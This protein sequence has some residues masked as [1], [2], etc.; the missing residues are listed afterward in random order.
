MGKGNVG[1]KNG[2]WKGGRTIASNGYVL[3]RVGRDHH[4]ADVRGYAYEHRIVAEQKIGR[5]L[6]KGEIVH[7][8][9]GI[10]TDNRFENIEV[11][12]GIAEHQFKHRRANL[13]RQAP[14]QINEIIEC[15]CGCGEKFYKFDKNK[16]PRSFVSGHNAG[17]KNEKYKNRMV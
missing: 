1:P 9:N 3:V 4:L 5:K 7:H 10:K 12:L 13:N 15:A 14:N 8:I 6:S 16:R 17:N 11:V 2:F